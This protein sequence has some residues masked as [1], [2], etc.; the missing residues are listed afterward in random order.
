[1]YLDSPHWSGTWSDRGSRLG[2]RGTAPLPARVRRFFAGLAE[3]ARR[4]EAALTIAAAHR[5]RRE[6]LGALDDRTL[7][8]IGLSRSEIGSVVTES[9]GLVEPTRVQILRS[10]QAA[11][12]HD[13]VADHATDHAGERRLAA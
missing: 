10:A 5:A 9:L 2:R 12:R 11:T 8:D 7:R 3:S 13:A 4:L 1:M 6:A